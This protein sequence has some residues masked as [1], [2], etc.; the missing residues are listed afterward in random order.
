MQFEF[1]EFMKWRKSGKVVARALRRGSLI[2][3][4]LYLKFSGSSID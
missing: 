2:I 1:E 4:L 3:F